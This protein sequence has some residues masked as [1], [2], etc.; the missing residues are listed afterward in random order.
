MNKKVAGSFI[1]A[2][3]LI[4]F[5]G[6]GIGLTRDQPPGQYA[7][8]PGMSSDNNY[9]QEDIPNNIE[10]KSPLLASVDTAQADNTYEATESSK[11][12]PENISQ[13]VKDEGVSQKQSPSSNQVA[14]NTSSNQKTV[15]DSSIDPSRSGVQH[16]SSKYNLLSKNQ[17]IYGQ[18]A[19]RNTSGGRIEV[20][21][22]WI[23]NN[24][25]TITLPGVNKQVQVHREA[26]DKFIKAFTYIKNG[27]VTIDG[28]RV[29]LLSL[30]KSMDGTF[31]TRHVNWNASNGLSNH[32]W[33]IAIDI[34][35][36]DHFRYVNPSREPNDPNLILW[37]N[38]FKPAGFSWGNSYNDAMHYELD[39]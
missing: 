12:V 34:N 21:P 35:A 24:I 1:L 39:S 3:L 28:K 17:G 27:S 4:G 7:P 9:Q 32:S 36:N 13:N 31:V 22:Q 2:V 18:F 10:E 29:S 30:I 15:Q 37:E 23:A 20:D 38:A 26:K 8:I 16:T 33:G 11:E 6:L 19:Y 14:V 25:V 5:V